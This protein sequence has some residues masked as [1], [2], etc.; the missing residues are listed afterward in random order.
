[1]VR[2][3]PAVEDPMISTSRS[4]NRMRCGVSSPILVD[5]NVL[6]HIHRHAR[7]QLPAVSSAS[8]RPS[9]RSIGGVPSRVASCRA[10]MDQ[11][12]LFMPPSVLCLT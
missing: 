6:D 5:L 1:M 12:L 9:M 10:T 3:Q 2:G 11:R 7:L 4:P 8:G